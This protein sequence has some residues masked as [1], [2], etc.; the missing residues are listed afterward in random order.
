MVNSRNLSLFLLPLISLIIGIYLQAVI[1]AAVVYLACCFFVF[2]CCLLITIAC[3]WRLIKLVVLNGLF[4]CA[5]GLVLSLQHA[6][7]EQLLATVA[8]QN[9][10]II[11]TVTDRHLQAANKSWRK[12]NEVLELAVTNIQATDAK[13]FASANF[14]LQCFVKHTTKTQVGDTILIKNITIKPPQSKTLSGNPGYGDY[15]LKEG[16]LSSIFLFSGWQMEIIKRPTWSI[17]RWWW[18]IRNNT[19]QDIVASLSP[20]SASYYSLI[21]LGKKDPESSDQLRRTFNF[22][23]LSHYLARSGLHIVLFILIWKFI[24]SCLPVHLII[25]RILLILICGTYG[26]FSWASTSFIRAFYSFLLSEAGRL[27][28][29]NV[30]FFHILTIVCLIMLL[31][32]PIQL[33]FLDFQLT[34]GLT[35]ALAWLSSYAWE[36]ATPQ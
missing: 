32:N 19:F 28:N 16:F 26:L 5:G 15:L 27:F 21:F 13:K 10:T 22:W 6:H 30:H 8:N 31:F 7:A 17:R 12:Q 23:G 34:F 33:F 20:R 18:S 9:L 24:L 29:F 4:L 1:P 3:K 14:T 11:A 36:N 25:K 35:F 2:I